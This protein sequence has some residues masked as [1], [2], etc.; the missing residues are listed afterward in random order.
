MALWARLE[1]QSIMAASKMKSKTPTFLFEDKQCTFKLKGASFHG[2]PQKKEKLTENKNTIT[3]TGTVDC[4]LEYFVRV[5]VKEK[6][7]CRQLIRNERLQK[8]KSQQRRPLSTSQ[9]D[10]R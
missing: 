4:F 9:L 10:N 5:F 6:A 1:K 8:N 3:L 2:S 7:G